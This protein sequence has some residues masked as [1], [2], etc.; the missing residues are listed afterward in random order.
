MQ[1]RFDLEGLGS[2]TKDIQISVE[3][4]LEEIHQSTWHRDEQYTDVRKEAEITLEPHQASYASQT[5]SRPRETYK[6]QH[7]RSPNMQQRNIQNADNTI[8]CIQ[9]IALVKTLPIMC[10]VQHSKAK[11]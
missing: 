11:S 4:S 7:N 6:I 1:M 8:L 2:C 3:T 5:Q 10:C 9:D